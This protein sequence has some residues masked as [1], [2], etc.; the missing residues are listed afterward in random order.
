MARLI[1][2]KTFI[3]KRGHLTVIEKVLPFE[4]KRIFYIYHVD[5]S[6][7]GSHRHRQTQQAVI[8]LRGHCTIRSHDGNRHEEFTMDD[9]A[10]CLILDPKDWHQMLDFSPDAM[11][12]VLASTHFDPDDYLYTPYP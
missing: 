2:L 7:R 12:M 11:L 1:N 6:I 4:I 8:C 9:P 3:D 5:D 10:K